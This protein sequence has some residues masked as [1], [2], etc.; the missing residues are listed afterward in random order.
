MANFPEHFHKLANHAS[1][2]QI[3]SSRLVPNY[4]AAACSVLYF[5][6]LLASFLALFFLYIGACK[7]Y[8]WLILCT[9]IFSNP[10]TRSSCV[11]LTQR[12][13]ICSQNL[14]ADF[15][16]GKSAQK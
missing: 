11:N 6:I 13:S 12:L 10:S 2:L 16:P 4:L 3:L 9:Y 14:R 15:V 1:F 5:S 7:I 8:N